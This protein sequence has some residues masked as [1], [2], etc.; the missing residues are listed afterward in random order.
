MSVRKGT[1]MQ[2]VKK[3]ACSLPVGINLALSYTVIVKDILKKSVQ[4]ACA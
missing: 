2:K 3:Y 1:L 4:F